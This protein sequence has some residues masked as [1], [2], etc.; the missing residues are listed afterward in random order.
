[1]TLLDDIKT[2]LENNWNNS[3]TDSRTPQI[4]NRFS[5][6]RINISTNDYILIRELTRVQ[7]DNGS[8][9]SSK[10]ITIIVSLD[11]RTMYS[12]EH[13]IKMRN[14]AERILN[15]HQINPFDNQEYEISD[16]SDE[17]DLTDG[18]VKIYRYEINIKFQ[19]LNAI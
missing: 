17:R 3:N 5:V 18:L 15:N 19:K 13:L 14:E 1:M 8:G 12:Y 7:E 6:K 2:L 16:I 9:A 10:H 11:L 4:T